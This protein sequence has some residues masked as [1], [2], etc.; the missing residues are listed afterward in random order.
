MKNIY[1]KRWVPQ[2]WRFSFGN[3][4]VLEILS[5]EL[6]SLTIIDGGAAGDISEPFNNLKGLIN[7]YRVE[8]R[9]KDTVLDSK[10]CTYIDG[11]L[12]KSRGPIRLHITSLPTASCVYPP[13]SDYLNYFEF[14]EA[15]KPRIVEKIVELDSVSIDGLFEIGKIDAPDIIKLDIHSSELDVLKGARKSLQNTCCVLV[16]TWH[17]PVHKNAGL[18]GEVEDFMLKQGFELFDMRVSSMWNNKNVDERILL[19]KKQLISSELLFFHRDRNQIKLGILFELFGYYQ[20]ALSSI[21][22][23]TLSIKDK[24]TWKEAIYLVS[25]RNRNNLRYLLLRL[26]A[27]IYNSIFN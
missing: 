6:I 18:S 1:S 8:P 3:K 13:N 20:N 27:K 26:S 25:K 23:S 21:E 4:R 22:K 19:D 9:G 5:H 16:E 10:D 14:N 15:L 24:S 11:A 7:S 17:N 12:S 2:F